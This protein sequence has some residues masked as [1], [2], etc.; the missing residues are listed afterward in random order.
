MELIAARGGNLLNASDLARDAGLN[1][2]TFT[3]YLDLLRALY[4]VYTLPA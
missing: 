4:L 2:V 3:R 1:N